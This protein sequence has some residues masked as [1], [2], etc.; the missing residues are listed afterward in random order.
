MILKLLK[1]CLIFILIIRPCFS[2]NDNYLPVFQG[3]NSLLKFSIEK[4]IDDFF[5][6]SYL[7]E[8]EDFLKVT[9]ATLTHYQEK[10]GELKRYKFYKGV[11]IDEVYRGYLILYYNRAPVY[12]KVDV[13]QQEI[14][15]FNLST[16]LD[17]VFPESMLFTEKNTSEH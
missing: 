14:T 1:P 15:Q 5:E 3:L 8:D 16:S 2:Q 12:L 9:R 10:Y 13:Y 6:K 11:Q 7:A 4:S 17:E